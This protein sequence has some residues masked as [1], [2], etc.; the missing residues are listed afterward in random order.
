MAELP[1]LSSLYNS[2][3][4]SDVL[5]RVSGKTFHAHRVFLSQ[6]GYF[7][8]LFASK[9][10]ETTAPVDGRLVLELNDIDPHCFEIY[11]KNLYGINDH[12]GLKFSEYIELYRETERFLTPLF[13]KKILDKIKE[14]HN[15]NLSRDDIVMYYEFVHVYNVLPPLI[16]SIEMPASVIC[17][18]SYP[19][20]LYLVSRLNDSTHL[21]ILTWIATH[22]E[23]SLDNL[24]ALV[25]KGKTNRL[26]R[27][28]VEI[29]ITYRDIPV[30]KDYILDLLYQTTLGK[31]SF[32]TYC[33]NRTYG[34]M[35]EMKQHLDRGTF[36]ETKDPL[37]SNTWADRPLDD[38]PEAISSISYDCISARYNGQ[39][40]YVTR[41][42]GFLHIYTGFDGVRNH[43]VVIGRLINGVTSYTLTDR[44][45]EHI[46]KKGWEIHP[47]C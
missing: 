15:K 22:P 46:R 37:S 25:Q 26:T 4:Y 11:L 8:G 23:T 1:F 21:P 12:S 28:E 18:L 14:A 35:L 5:I 31:V 38:S 29:V 17:S 42:N 24:K 36:V 20:V 6:S 45:K 9:M 47:Q 3:R 30:L 19:A 13:S 41:I 34:E 43:I 16:T 2:E 7:E 33:L 32:G 10:K 39:T 40:I 27:E 44:E